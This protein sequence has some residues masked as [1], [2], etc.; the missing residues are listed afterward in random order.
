VGDAVPVIA[1]RGEM[2]VPKDQVGKTG[3]RISVVQNFT[4]VAPDPATA[5]QLVKAQKFAIAQAVVEAVEQAPGIRRM[6]R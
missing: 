3:L 2:I 6:L 5:A 1:H 4:T